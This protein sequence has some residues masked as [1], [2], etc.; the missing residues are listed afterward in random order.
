[1]ITSKKTNMGNIKLDPEKE[2]VH[3][4]KKKPNSLIC[5]KRGLV[6][7]TTIMNTACDLSKYYMCLFFSCSV[8]VSVP[9]IC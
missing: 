7:I 6:L 3:L 5:C 9:K 8:E 1:M 2:R 4:C